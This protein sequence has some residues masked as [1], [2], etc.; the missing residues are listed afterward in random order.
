MVKYFQ[1]FFSEHKVVT[2]LHYKVLQRIG[3]G[4]FKGS[5]TEIQSNIILNDSW[6][7]AE[8]VLFALGTEINPCILK[9]IS[10]MLLQYFQSAVLECHRNPELLPSSFSYK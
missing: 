9:Y 7:T 2:H 3:E 1:D 10:L 5:L 4:K 8:N 6:T